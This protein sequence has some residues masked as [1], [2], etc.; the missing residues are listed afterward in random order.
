MSPA[1]QIAVIADDITGAADTG[2]QFCPAVGP[3]C[4]A[5]AIKGELTAAAIQTAGMAVFTNSRHMDAAVAAQI[6]RLAGEKIHCLNPRVIYKKIDSCLRGNLGAEIDALLEVIGATASFIAPAFPQQGRTT[7]NDCH[8]IHGIPVAETEIGRDPLCPVRES[9]L[10]ARLSA[11]TRMPVGHVDLASIED[12][13]ARLVQ[14]V[15]TLLNRGC[16]HIAFD[17][18]KTIHLNT[19]AGL[20]RD[21][22]ENI[23]LVG[24]AGLASSLSR[25]MERQLPC[26]EPTKRPGIKKWLFVC[27][28]ASRVLADQ[29]ARLA[30]STGWA[31]M[32]I[33]PAALSAGSNFVR[34]QLVAEIMNAR[35][36]GSLILSIQPILESGPI[37]NPDLVVKGLAQVAAEL[38]PAVIPDGVF[39]SGGD[40]VEAFWQRIGA[41]ALIIREEILSGLMRGE[42]VGGPQ[43]GLC[44]V[45]KAGAFGHA[46]TLNQLINS[47]K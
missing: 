27:G 15:R 4:L 2:G 8:L 16:R 3:V 19:I 30:S 38:L 41:S 1:L 9:R 14:R 40:T 12:S 11:Q 28:S 26:P 18:E 35:V 34:E 25:M 45:T 7:M 10:S 20:A 43:N 32:A 29:V 5:G 31:H 23:L 37:A 46:D 36:V 39:L 17:A 33:D 44:L 22:F 47:L 24:S 6:V 13:P 42:F 21:H